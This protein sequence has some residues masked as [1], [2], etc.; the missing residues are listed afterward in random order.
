[1]ARRTGDRT[2]RVVFTGDFYRADG[3]PLLNNINPGW[4]DAYDDIEAVAFNEH[5]PAIGADQLGD[6][7]G[8]VVL[9]PAVTKQSVSN[10]EDLLAVGRFGV[11]YDKV[12]VQACT[13]ADVLVYITAG[14]VD[15]PVAEAA[16]MWILGLSHMVLQK[17]K[18][19]RTTGWAEQSKY[20]GREIRDRVLGVVG[21]GGIGRT[22][23]E[24]VQG[25][26]FQEILAFDPFVESDEARRIG[27]RLVELDELLKLSD[28]VSLHCPLNKSTRHL[29][30][31]REL[32]LMRE[33]AYLI[34]TARGAVVD[35]EALYHALK[36][37]SI[38]GA[39]IDCYAEEPLPGPP[40]LA[41]LENAIL[42]PHCIAW[43]E[44][45]VRDVGNSVCQ[46][47]V[48]LANGTPP[49]RMVNPEV[50]ESSGFQK[51]W[52]R[53]RSDASS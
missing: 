25:L 32:A 12:D 52:S 18:L 14:A 9:T 16:L 8:V 49:H 26:G 46:G 53:F 50:I 43:T 40:K 37:R 3:S 28:F 42:A 39:A 41:E 22:L 23:V 47:M 35:E 24:L 48:D 36:N 33:D 6:A 21:L 19:V 31:E 30:G 44:E 29:I 51:K 34:N 38:A 15:R 1:M 2:F 10:G 20:V 27:V 11:G 13:D 4:Y 17:D 7:Q 5:R 45:L